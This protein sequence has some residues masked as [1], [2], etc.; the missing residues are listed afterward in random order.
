MRRY[1]EAVAQARKGQELDP[2]SGFCN[3]HF[4]H[5]LWQARRFDEAIEEFRKWLA[6]EPNDWF[7]HH[8]L[9]H[10]YL[11]K[12]MFKEAIAEMNKS[13]ELSGGVPMN[14]ANAAM[15]HYRFGDK[16][17]ADQLFESLKKRACREYIQPTG[18]VLIHLARGEADQAFEWIKKAYEERDSFLP[19]FRVTP[20]DCMRFPSDPRVNEL[21][22]RL[23]LP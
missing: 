23:G 13:L 9:S 18:F 21:L 16:E 2:L 10:L 15:T 3:T 6:I 7:S 19:W 4:A 17:V 22:D 1:D 20:L 14:V 8:H 12:S 11:E 5:R